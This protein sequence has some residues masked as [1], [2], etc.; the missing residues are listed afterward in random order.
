MCPAG[1]CLATFCAILFL[2]IPVEYFSFWL[3]L[4]RVGDCVQT[5]MPKRKKVL[6][7]IFKH[8]AVHRFYI[9]YPTPINATWKPECFC[10]TE[11]VSLGLVRGSLL[12]GMA[13]EPRS[14]PVERGPCRAV[15]PGWDLSSGEAQIAAHCDYRCQHPAALHGETRCG[16][17]STVFE[18]T[19]GIKN[20]ILAF[21]VW[22][23]FW[24]CA[25]YLFMRL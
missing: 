8:L 12:R 23:Y 6:R 1:S 10:S 19:L 20:H 17:P 13:L 21:V 14:S 15:V 16:R 3:L 9:L 5:H 25:S 11:Q 4:W 18:I 2:H 22:V 7:K 24:F